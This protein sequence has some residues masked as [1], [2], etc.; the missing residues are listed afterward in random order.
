VAGKNR[1]W[2]THPKTV[3][4][5]STNRARRRVTSLI[6]RMQLPLCQTVNT[7]THIRQWASFNV[8]SFHKRLNKHR[9]YQLNLSQKLPKTPSAVGLVS[10][11]Q[12]LDSRFVILYRKLRNDENNLTRYNNRNSTC[13]CRVYITT[14]YKVSSHSLAVETVG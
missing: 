8:K 2:F 3:T 4:H 9:N 10:Y 11:K 6:R 5:P 1:R 13:S 7:H 12:L 14:K